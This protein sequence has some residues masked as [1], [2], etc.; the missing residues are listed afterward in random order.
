MCENDARW[1][2]TLPEHK[3]IAGAV[4][5]KGDAPQVAVPVALA[6]D[7]VDL[8]R[9]NLR[10]A[11]ELGYV[12]LGQLIGHAIAGATSRTRRP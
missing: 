8:Q 6:D 9:E 1:P 12:G 5:P 7:L 2:K 11:L 4:Q 10:Y 3:E